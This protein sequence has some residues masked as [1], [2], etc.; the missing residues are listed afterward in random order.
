MP[1]RVVFDVYGTLL[2]I[3]SPAARLSGRIGPKAAHC[4]DLW[5]AKQL[6]YSWT[7]TFIG[8]YEP[9]WNLTERALDY[10]LAALDLTADAGLK[11]ALLDAYTAPDV[12]REVTGALE[13]IRA[14]GCKTA[15]F[16]NGD[17]A[18]LETALGNTGL[19]AL[20]DDVVSVDPVRCF[21]PD[22]RVY[23]Y[24][25]EVL[26]AADE[27]LFVSSNGWDAAGAA[28][29]GWRT[30]WVSRKGHEY[31]F[32][33]RAAADITDSLDGVAALLAA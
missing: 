2:D 25:A 3:A 23:A 29:F 24:C 19:R 18:M 20:F 4:A 12:H 7:A 15:V 10:T 28:A 14:A 33:P 30:V 8:H 22:R 5:R 6:E 1:H 26:G 13:R 17:P 27:I 32:G 9:F 31:E 16:S 21:K 11:Q